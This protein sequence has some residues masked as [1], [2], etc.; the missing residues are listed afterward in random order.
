[1]INQDQ[2]AQDQAAL[3]Q[4]QAADDA[5]RAALAAADT[6]LAGAAAK[7]QADTAE[8]DAEQAK[9]AANP[10]LGILDEMEQTVAKFQSQVGVG[11]SDLFRALI[12]KARTIVDP[13]PAPAA[14]P[15]TPVVA[16]PAPV[17]STTPETTGVQDAQGSDASTTDQGTA[18]AG[19]PE[20]AQAAAPAGNVVEVTEPVTL[21]PVGGDTETGTVVGS[22]ADTAVTDAA[23][24]TVYDAQTA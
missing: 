15:E 5:A 21:T 2:L 4:S 7:L 17:A 1:M 12:A 23:P 9:I 20:Q 18:E 24:G 8:Y 6:S 13:A 10:V 22:G 11:V 19:A 3:A 14:Q 16:D